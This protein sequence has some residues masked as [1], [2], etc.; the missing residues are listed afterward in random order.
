MA[1][2]PQQMADRLLKILEEESGEFVAML[3]EADK[4]NI[5]LRSATATKE[6]WQATIEELQ[7]RLHNIKA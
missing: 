3:S 1:Q 4:L 5:C 2:T 6:R 7:T